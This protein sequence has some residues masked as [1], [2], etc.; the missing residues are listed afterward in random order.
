LTENPTAQEF[1]YIDETLR[2][3]DVGGGRISLTSSGEVHNC[4]GS[5]AA[6]PI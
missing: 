3:K 2:K 1:M 4:L 5:M 6:P